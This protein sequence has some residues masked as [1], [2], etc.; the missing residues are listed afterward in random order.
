[1][2]RMAL[3]P[4][5]V[6]QGRFEEVVYTL[7][8]LFSKA[9]Q[10]TSSLLKEGLDVRYNYMDFPQM[11]TVSY[12]NPAREWGN[13]LGYKEYPLKHSNRI[14]LI[15]IISVSQSGRAHIPKVLGVYSQSCIVVRN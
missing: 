8:S 11:V 9:C 15:N 12:R 3:P 2:L 5:T 7:P 1:M 4:L 14:Y 6:L 13:H 10:T